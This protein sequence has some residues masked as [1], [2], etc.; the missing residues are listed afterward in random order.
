MTAPLRSRSF[1]VREGD[2]RNRNSWRAVKVNAL[3]SLRPNRG[4]RGR[5]L[6]DEQPHRKTLS[7]R[8]RQR[9]IQVALDD[10]SLTSFA[11]ATPQQSYLIEQLWSNAT[12]PT[13][14]RTR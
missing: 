2:S 3:R 1:W 14:P 4:R 13:Q 12:R 5:S 10:P 11:T 9:R 8:E 6:L 7:D